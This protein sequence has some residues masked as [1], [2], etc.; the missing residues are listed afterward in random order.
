MFHQRGK[1]NTL[2]HFHAPSSRADGLSAPLLKIIDGAL[3]GVI[4]LL[5]FVMGGRHPLGQLTLAILAVTASLAWAIRQ[6][7]RPHPVWR[8]TWALALISAGII[9]VSLQSIPLPQGVLELLAPSQA[10]ILPLWSAGK[11]DSASLGRWCTIS[12]AP[13]QT[14]E[15]GAADILWAVVFR[16]GRAR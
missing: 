9:L 1:L 6:C 13:Y 4:F 14:R 16:N 3:A 7:F 8:P 11:P 12:F 2:R 5:P 15:S 10:K